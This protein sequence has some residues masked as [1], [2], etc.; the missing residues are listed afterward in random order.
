MNCCARHEQPC[1]FSVSAAISLLVG[2]ANAAPVAV[3]QPGDKDL[4]CPAIQAEVLANNAQVQQLASEEG[5]KVAQNVA[6]GVVGL[7]IWP[8]WFA[9]DFKGAASKDET[10]LQSRQQYL[11]VLAAQ[12]NCGTPPPATAAVAAPSPSAVAAIPVSAVVPAA[13][14]A[15]AVT[16]QVTALPPPKE[17]ARRGASRCC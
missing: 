4:D 10:A 7:F 5:G 16:P 6:A 3:V 1:S 14:P 17:Y 12:R 9:M 8:V 2:G 13:A 15:A 11:A